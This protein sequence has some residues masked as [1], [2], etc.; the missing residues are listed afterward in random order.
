MHENNT[1]KCTTAQQNDAAVTRSTRANNERSVSEVATVTNA[2]AEIKKSN[3][4]KNLRYD[5]KWEQ[6][7]GT[8]S[9][10]F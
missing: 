10:K 3:I 6:K 4:G 8:K 2:H 1:R 9:I 5:P 7:W